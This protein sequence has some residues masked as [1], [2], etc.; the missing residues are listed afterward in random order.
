MS[1]LP[2]AFTR[3]NV[4][5]TTIN[6]PERPTP[7]LEKVTQVGNQKHYQSSRTESELRDMDKERVE[8]RGWHRERDKAAWT[9]LKGRDMAQGAG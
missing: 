6:V 4:L 7:A 3:S 1:M 2:S 9:G 8:D 5:S